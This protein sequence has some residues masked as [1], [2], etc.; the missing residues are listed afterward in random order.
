MP[1][2]QFYRINVDNET[3]YHIYAGQQDNT[4][5]KIASRAIGA[6]G[7]DERNW[8][9][10][11]GGESA[12]LAFDPNNPRYV[13]G[14]SYQGTIEVLDTKTK[15]S[16]NIMAAPIQ[17]LGRDA[18]DIKYR[19]NWNAPIIW[20]KHEPNTYYHGAQYLLK[21][22]D[23]G[24]TWKEVSPDLTRNEKSKQGKPGVPYT[25]EAVGAENYGTLA[26]V[27]ESVHE[28]GV[29][30]TGSDDGL[31]HVTKDGGA[32]WKN[33]T[34]AGLAECLINAIEVSPHDKATVYIATTRYKFNDHTPGLYKSTDYGTTWTKINTG[35]ANNAFTRVVREDDVVKDLLFAGTEL[36]VYISNNGGKNWSPF[37]LNLPLTPITDLRVHQNNLIAATSGRSFWILDDLNMVRQFKA[38]STA[39][40]L[41]NP[42]NT[43]LT[44]GYSELDNND[45]SFTGAKT[46][47]GVNP[48]TGMVLYYQLPTLPDSVELTLEIRNAAGQ[49][50]RSFSS[51]ADENFKRYDG[52]PRR[53]PTLSK[54]KGLNRFVWNL[55]H[56]T[57]TAIPYVYIESSFNGHK[58]IPGS[59]SIKLIAGS[60]TVSTTGT[61]LAN[62]NYTT[63]AADYQ[64]YDEVMT[65]M[66]KTVS[67]MHQMVNELKDNSN[68]LEILLKKLKADANYSGTRFASLTENATAL[69]AKLKAWDESMIQRKSTSYDDVENFPNKFTANY[70]FLMNQTESDIPQVN[71]PSLDLLKTYTAEWEQ[72]KAT[73]LQLKNEAIPALNKQLWDLGLGAIW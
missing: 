1:T 27:M 47:A 16:T 73:G 17:Y 23:W 43:L 44:T 69:V 51:K 50:V 66:E 46:N 32:N 41:Y 70:M 63:T 29:I 35:I 58:V 31:V 28:K 38:D 19:Y 42:S 72:L 61:V 34:P 40:K 39:I 18:K 62:P 4:S 7:I 48:A 12:F 33:I 13:L 60:T 26:Y 68:R 14:G 20:S 24:K 49:L 45:A 56:A 71:Q 53:E 3:P 57:T 37:Q 15:A 52:G 11:A 67:E 65:K 21:T 2:A 30:Y 22:S 36:G 10:S 55:R 64:L 54:T 6:G 59:Y 5:V 25:N 9:A 8:S